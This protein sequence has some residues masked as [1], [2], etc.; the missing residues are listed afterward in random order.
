[1]FIHKHPYKPFIPEGTT[2]LIVGTLP[3][4]R[5]SMGIL[6]KGDVDF[7]YG[8]IDGQLWKILDEIFSLSLHFETTDLAIQQRKKFLV[9]NNMGICDIVESCERQ[10]MDAS[11]L[12]MEHIILR[13]LLFYI[14]KNPS[15]HTLLLTGG[16]SKNGPKYHL[17]RQLK[18]KNITLKLISSETPK[19]HEFEIQKNETSRKIKIISLTAPSGSANRAVGSNP[20]YQLIKKQNPK[21]NTLD[22][23]VLQYKKFF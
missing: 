22:F 4:P 16:S 3:P 17:R 18:E 11:D 9:E 8:S 1:M 13:D 20:Q 5:F 6:K 12:G 15:V 19:I 23:R 7:C 14:D 2:K 10:K 21:F